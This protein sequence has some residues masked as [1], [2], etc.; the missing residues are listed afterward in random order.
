[1]NFR[2]IASTVLYFLYYKVHFYENIGEVQ[3]AIRREIPAESVVI[4][5]LNTRIVAAFFFSLYE[6]AIT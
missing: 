6:I 5:S 1:M 2:K 4:V 3:S